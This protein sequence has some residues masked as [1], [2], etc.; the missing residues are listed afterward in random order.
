MI[1]PFSPE[2]GHLLNRMLIASQLKKGDVINRKEVNPGV[3]QE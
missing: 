1:C 2:K 3:F